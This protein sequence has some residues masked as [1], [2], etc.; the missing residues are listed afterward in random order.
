MLSCTP[1]WED[2]AIRK[3]GRLFNC[4]FYKINTLQILLNRR[5]GKS[6]QVDPKLL[7]LLTPSVLLAV[8]N[9]IKTNW[10]M[11]IHKILCNLYR[12][13]TVAPKWWVFFCQCLCRINSPLYTEVPWNLTQAYLLLLCLMRGNPVVWATWCLWGTSEDPYNQEIKHLL[14]RRW[15]L[16]KPCKCP[17][18]ALSWVLQRAQER[19]VRSHPGR[20]RVVWIWPKTV[21]FCEKQLQCCYLGQWQAPPTTPTS[22][23][24]WLSLVCSFTPLQVQNAALGRKRFVILI[25]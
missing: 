8:L 2:A 21:N 25:P 13:N 10:Q 15:H 11:A 19:G 23:G 4:R 9:H 24:R 7:Q 6:R 22:S 14:V 5:W 1:S 3:G 12:N 20:K 16:W 18:H 17:G